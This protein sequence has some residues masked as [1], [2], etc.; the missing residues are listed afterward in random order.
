MILFHGSVKVIE[1]PRYGAGRNDNDYGQAFYCTDR[2]ELAREWAAVSENGGFVNAYSMDMDGMNLLDLRLSFPAEG[3]LINENNVEGILRWLSLLVNYRHLRLGSPV[4]RKGRDYL[5]SRYLPDLTDVDCILGYR[6]D[7]SYFSFARA[8]LS[9][10][11]TLGQLALAMYLG[12]LGLQYAIR[13]ARMFDR[14]KFGGAEPVD[15]SMYYP[16]RIHRD[17]AAR[18]KYRKLLEEEASDGLYLSDLM[19]RGRR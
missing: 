9:N 15:G 16:M 2:I 1:E 10:T 5:I 6:A 13:S 17:H 3:Q 14:L 19:R 11:T 7:D 8:F 18:E 4:E 12:D